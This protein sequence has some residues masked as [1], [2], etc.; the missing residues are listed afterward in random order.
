MADPGLTGPVGAGEN[1]NGPSEEEIIARRI[2]LRILYAL[3]YVSLY[4]LIIVIYSGSLATD[5]I[6]L[7][8]VT[9]VLETELARSTTIA[10]FFDFL[11]TGL[12]L[13]TVVLGI[14]HGLISTISL[15]L[16]DYD[17]S[18]NEDNDR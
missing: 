10:R 6:I 16:A 7:E 14:A 18:I 4:A 15:I 5:Y 12:A 9:L 2:R 8:M 11:R 13:M 1:G 3:D 17:A